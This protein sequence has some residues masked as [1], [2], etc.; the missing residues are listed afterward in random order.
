MRKVA[1]KAVSGER[2]RIFWRANFDDILC[3]VQLD[4]SSLK[5]RLIVKVKLFFQHQMTLLKWV[6]SHQ[7]LLQLPDLPLSH[8]E[9]Q[10]SSNVCSSDGICIRGRSI[11]FTYNFVTANF[12]SLGL[13]FIVS[14]DFGI[15]L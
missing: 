8:P 15:P 13:K 7:R 6:L 2:L 5:D 9:F 4:F 3:L 1:A 11:I 12:N 10:I 14:L